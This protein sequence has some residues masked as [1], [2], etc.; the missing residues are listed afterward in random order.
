MRVRQILFNLVGNAIKFTDRGF[1]RVSTAA[2][3]RRPTGLC[4][5]ASPSATAG[6]AW[7]SRR[8]P[9]LFQPFTQ[10]DSRRRHGASA[11]PVTGSVDLA[12]ARPIDGRGRDGPQRVRRG[13][14]ASVVTLRLDG[15]APALVPEAAAARYV[16]AVSGAPGATRRGSL[17]PTTIR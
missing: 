13:Q 15:A 9:R 11:E 10:A 17:S 1:V 5:S 4:W 6:S 14:Q 8:A 12:P 2:P 3:A 7:T 16:S